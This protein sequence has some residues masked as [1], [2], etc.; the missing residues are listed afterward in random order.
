MR[1]RNIKPGFF[2]NEVLAELDPLTRILFA[3]LWCL[4]D[5]DGRLEERVRRIQ[6]E[7][8]PYETCDCNAMLQALHDKHFIQ[9]YEAN[10]NKYIQVVRFAQHQNPHRDEKSL[11]L[12]PP[13]EQHGGSTVLA[14]CQHSVS[15][16]SAPA[17]HSCNPADSLNTNSLY[18]DSLK[19]DTKD[20]LAFSMPTK[21]GKTCG[22]KQ[23]SVDRWCKA[24]PNLDVMLQLER[25][26]TWLLDNPARG[27]TPNGMTR[28][29][30]SWLSRAEQDRISGRNDTRQ[31]AMERL[32]SRPVG[33][34]W[35]EMEETE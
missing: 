5:R 2:K 1:A 33:P 14:P 26:K 23:S 21:A 20:T 7:I 11:N 12:P 13:P 19:T 29:I 4:A 18:T 27:K 24:Y 28:F 3:G 34:G 16:V 15:T 10:D 32:A 17:Q 25:A 35:D 31:S 8:L 30:G 9:R 22:I 6:M